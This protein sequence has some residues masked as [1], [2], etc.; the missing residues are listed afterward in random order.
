MADVRAQALSVLKQLVNKAAPYFRNHEVDVFSTLIQL[1]G[2]YP[3]Q[4]LVSTNIEEVAE[5]FIPIADPSPSISSIVSILSQDDREHSF[6]KGQSWCLALSALSQLIKT[7]KPSALPE[8][9]WQDLGAVAVKA[10]EDEDPEIRRSCTTMCVVMQKRI[11]DQEKFF[12]R[13]MTG[14]DEGHRNLLTY[15]F[16]RG[17]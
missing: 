4:S 7:A 12:D 2:Y 17:L 5:D 1:R 3:T 8:A 15:Y 9:R 14:L 11:G 13:Y 16:A 6:L 10:L